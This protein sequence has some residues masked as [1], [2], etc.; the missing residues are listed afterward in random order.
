M[1]LSPLPVVQSLVTSWWSVAVGVGVKAA[2]VLVV[3]K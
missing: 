1:E 3:E 2:V